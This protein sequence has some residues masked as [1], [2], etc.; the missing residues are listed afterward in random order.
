MLERINRR[1]V[2]C[3]RCPELRTYCA[4]VARE[5]KLA[6]RDWK[7]WGRPVPS[8]GDPR[9]Q[10]LLVGLAPGAHGSNRTG[11]P[12]T[13]DGSGGFLYPALYRAGFANQP[14]AIA[15]DDGLRLSNCMITAAV[16]CAPPANKPTPQ[17]LHNCAPY[18]AD[19][20]DALDRLRVIVAL[21]AIAQRAVVEMLREASFEIEPRRP[22]FGH[23][24]EC[25]AKRDRRVVTMIASFHPSRQNTNTGKLTAPMF[26]RIFARAK[27]LLG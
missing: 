5:R 11:R 7:Y 15:R 17:Q 14:N 18:L 13:G 12:F 21:G 3:T 4:Q 1:V 22:A 10:L 16:R 9:A 20:F 23:G 27:A 19:E 2:R 6:F 24:A 26:D 8:F 25:V